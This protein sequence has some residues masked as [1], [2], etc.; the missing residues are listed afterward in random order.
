MIDVRKFAWALLFLAL[1]S[2]LL[3][4]LIERTAISF[5]GPIPT[6]PPAETTPIV[7]VVTATPPPVTMGPAAPHKT[8]TPMVFI[9]ALPRQTPATA[10]PEPTPV[11]LPQP[12]ETPDMSR[13][14]QR[15]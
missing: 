3:G 5:R 11:F 2:L 15:G 6:P 10:T 1:V 4:L 8:A 9:D 7:V 12:T 14:V 13:A